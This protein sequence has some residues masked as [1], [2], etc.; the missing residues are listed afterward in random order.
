MYHNSAGSD[1]EFRS[2]HRTAALLVV[3]GVAGR[4]RTPSSLLD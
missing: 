1:E 4:G 3:A 2:L